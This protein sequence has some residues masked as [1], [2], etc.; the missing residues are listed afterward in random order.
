M[1]AR[2]AM[3]ICAYGKLAEEVARMEARPEEPAPSAHRS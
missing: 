2:L 1:A 3:L